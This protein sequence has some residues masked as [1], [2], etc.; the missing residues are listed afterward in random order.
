VHGVEDAQFSQRTVS[1]SR[2][3]GIEHEVGAGAVVHLAL[4]QDRLR[5]KLG[6]AGRAGD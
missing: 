4:A 6:I 5:L 2:E 3:A 1:T